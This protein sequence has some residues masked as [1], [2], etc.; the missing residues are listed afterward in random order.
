MNANLQISYF[1]LELFASLACFLHQHDKQPQYKQKY[2]QCHS[3]LKSPLKVLSECHHLQ[4]PL[5][6]N[7]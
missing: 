6:A 3:H 1:P 4:L 2:H 7:L 5:A